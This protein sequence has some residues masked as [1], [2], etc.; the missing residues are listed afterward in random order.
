M[1]RGRPTKHRT[2]SGNSRTWCLHRGASGQELA[3][4]IRHEV[5]NRDTQQFGE[6]VDLIT[7]H[8][9]RTWYIE[10][11]YSSCLPRPRPEEDHTLAQ[12]EAELVE[13][14]V[15]TLH[16]I[17]LRK[18]YNRETPSQDAEANN[19][20]NTTSSQSRS[21][22]PSRARTK[23]DAEAMEETC[24][25]DKALGEVP[26][27]KRSP[28]RLWKELPPRKKTAEVRKLTP[29]WKRNNNPPLQQ[30][31][32]PR[33]PSRSPPRAPPKPKPMPTN[34]CDKKPPAET[35]IPAPNTPPQDLQA[36][37]E[38]ERPLTKEDA[39]A[40]WQALLEMQPNEGLD[41]AATPLL[42]QHVA[43]NIVETMVDRPSHEH[44]LLV[45]ELPAF[46]GRLQMDIGRALSRSREM[47]ARM[48]GAGSSTDPPPTDR[49]DEESIYMQT[50]MDKVSKEHNQKRLLR[51][52]QLAFEK[53]DELTASSRAIRMAA[54]LQDYDGTLQVDRGDLEALLVSFSTQTPNQPTGDAAILEYGW[55]GRWWRRMQGVPE[56]DREQFDYDIEVF[57]QHVKRT[58]EI[59]QAEE[60]HQD[61]AEQMY[62]RGLEETANARQEQLK[63][64]A[65][66]QEDDEV[67]RQA[68]GMTWK[69]AA[70][71][72][73]VGN[74]MSVKAF[75]WELD[76]GAEL[77]L[78]LKA[79]KR[80]CPGQ[81]Y[82]DGKPV[83]P[84]LVPS[85]LRIPP[86]EAAPAEPTLPAQ[87]DLA[88]PA[89]KELYERWKRGE[90]SD[91]MVVSTDM[92]AVFQATRD[93]PGEVLRD[94]DDRDTLTL[95]PLRAQTMAT[96]TEH[97]D[98]HE[99]NTLLLP[100][101]VC[102]ESLPDRSSGSGQAPQDGQPEPDAANH[103]EHT[104]RRTQT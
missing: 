97:E 47:R 50:N 25:M 22:T 37:P 77:Q 1:N 5:R 28:T 19:T 72:L 75:D 32:E 60:A 82:Q 49:D 70:K 91:Q 65:S 69:P 89:T 80:E 73:C 52:L 59:K 7:N 54:K 98:T 56:D 43:D 4:R 99:A 88:K 24:L 93:I 46:L 95:E 44:D 61:A 16:T 92:L 17:W 14:A 71:R 20:D 79:T 87:H 23:T 38:E 39:M 26:L 103:R 68:L 48:Q 27:R 35:D 42:P 76:R 100:K 31:G 94:L 62:L 45:D 85:A 8:F 18:R 53:L 9:Q 90:I 29:P 36:E 30:R 74:G 41:T 84:H 57:E 86:A 6:D 2:G 101:P 67:M 83:P 78:H 102:L 13:Q 10:K 63:A 96:A 81:W 40:V 34:R 64:Q 3:D 33:E 12:E 104:T 15:H 51:E 21:R 66:Q 11:K 55:V 58:N